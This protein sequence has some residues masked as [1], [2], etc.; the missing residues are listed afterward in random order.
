MAILI[1]NEVRQLSSGV[2]IDA[3][4][5]AANAVYVAPVSKKVMITAV[6]LRCTFATSITVG[7]SAKV[8]INAA[9]G[10]IFAEEVLID[11]LNVDDQW[12]FAA[13]ARGLVLPAGAQVDVTITNP[14]TGTAQTLQA[15]VIGYF[16]F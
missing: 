6:V 8:E 5:G 15:D 4:V 7:A 13:E 11:V 12:S 10:D 2:A 14:A 1:G 3:K 9:A 16:I